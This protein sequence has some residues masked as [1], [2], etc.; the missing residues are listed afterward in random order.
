MNGDNTYGWYWKE[1]PNEN[2]EQTMVEAFAKMIDDLVIDDLVSCQKQSSRTS[3]A[4]W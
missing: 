4:I 1:S 2:Q 3:L